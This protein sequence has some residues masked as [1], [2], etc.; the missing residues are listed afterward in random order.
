MYK[1][2]VFDSIGIIPDSGRQKAN[3]KIN[4]NQLDRNSSKIR[5]LYSNPNQGWPDMENNL[6]GFP[7]NPWQILHDE[8]FKFRKNEI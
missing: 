7:E 4:Q 3:K 5:N 1:I 8:L 2:A 6:I